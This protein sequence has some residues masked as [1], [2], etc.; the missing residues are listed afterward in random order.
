MLQLRGRTDTTEFSPIQYLSL[1]DF[2][3]F[4]QSQL[5]HD[6]PYPR[7]PRYCGLTPWMTGDVYLTSLL[8]SFFAHP[9][10]ITTRQEREVI[11]HCRVT[12][13]ERH[14]TRGETVAHALPGMRPP[15]CWSRTRTITDLCWAWVTFIASK[16]SLTLLSWCHC[17]P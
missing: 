17:F 9:N 5:V 6:V 14:R 7:P 1:F 10:T 3:I 8:I 13:Q 11:C 2:A 16:V 15:R 12:R 4:F